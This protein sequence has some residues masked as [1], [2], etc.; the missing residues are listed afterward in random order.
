MAGIVSYNSGIGVLG[1]LHCNHLLNTFPPFMEPPD[2]VP[3]SQDP[4]LK[5]FLSQLMPVR[6]L[7]L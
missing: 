4:A 5:A 7:L 1:K 6:I 2:C 3:S